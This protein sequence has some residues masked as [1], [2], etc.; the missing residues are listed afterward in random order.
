MVGPNIELERVNM[1]PQNDT[2]CFSYLEWQDIYKH[3]RPYQI[4]VRLPPGQEDYPTTNLK[5]KIN[6][7]EVIHD[8]R[9][10]ETE[11]SLD[12]HGFIFREH[13]V[14]S[15]IFKDSESMEKCYLPAVEALLR[16]H[17]DGVDRVEFFDYRVS[18]STDHRVKGH[19]FSIYWTN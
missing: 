8:V 5:F 10:R 1:E 17:V 7:K 9:G 2:A 4:F 15:D 11:F 16:Q 14:N 3:E 12:N 6:D 19:L 13:P 18:F